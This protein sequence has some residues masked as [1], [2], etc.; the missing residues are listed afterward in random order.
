MCSYNSRF[1]RKQRKKYFA[2]K[3]IRV[4]DKSFSVTTVLGLPPPQTAEMTPNSESTINS[5]NV[6]E[7]TVIKS[8]L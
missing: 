1:K 6:Y 8:K 2:E 7:L 4:P 5:L 3:G